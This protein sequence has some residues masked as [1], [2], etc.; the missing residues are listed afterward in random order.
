MLK[1]GIAVGLGTD[2]ASSNNN[3]DMIEEM[4][5]CALLHKV[6]SMDPT[7]L[8]AYQAL[9]MATALGAKALGWNDQIGVLKPGYKADII[10][11]DLNAAHMIPRYDILANIVYASQAADVNTVIINGQIIMENRRIT[12][13]DEQEVLS[14]CKAIAGDL[15]TR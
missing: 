2:G 9:E 5:S 3:L 13:F 8:P 10:L 4:R 12:Q 7:V 1:A 6:N 15:I 11:I 14:K